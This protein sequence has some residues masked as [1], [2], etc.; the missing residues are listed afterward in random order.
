[1][2]LRDLANQ[3]EVLP[4]DV[5]DYPSLLNVFKAAQPHIVYH[6]AG[7]TSVRKFDGDWDAVDRA[8]DVN[9]IGTLNV[10]RAARDSGAPVR[11]V[12]RAGGLEEYGT[13]FAPAD[14][15]QREQPSSPYSASQMAA[16]HWCQMLQEHV[17]F[18]ITTLRPALVYGPGQ[19]A[20]F[21]IPALISCLLRDQRF[22]IS[23][24]VQIR[25]YVYIDDVID[26]FQRAGRCDPSLRAAVVNISSGNQY[27]VADV[28]TMI[29]ERMGLA[30]LLDIGGIMHRP[31]DL[32]NV[33]GVNTL[34]LQLLGWN[35]QVALE[36]GLDRTIDWFRRQ[37][38]VGK[39]S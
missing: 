14:E 5:T 7:D 39:P 21:L 4:V 35:P 38:Q 10:V 30:H 11:S 25:D 27:G 32:P 18:A 6:L 34:A 12:V 22:S 24:G 8:I 20:D 29:A 31:G 23:D 26:A 3:I 37:I 13:G 9:L 19:G 33:S 15:A 16:T 1:M 2:R 17:S 28:A 36:E